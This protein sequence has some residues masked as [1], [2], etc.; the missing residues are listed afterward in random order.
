[1]TRAR[2]RETLTK[3]PTQPAVKTTKK[4]KPPLPSRLFSNPMEVINN[5]VKAACEENKD[6]AI[7]TV[8]PFVI[9]MP[10]AGQRRVSGVAGKRKLGPRSLTGT[11][12][13]GNSD[14]NKEV[15]EVED[16]PRKIQHNLASKKWRM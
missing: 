4:K 8:N 5:K 7:L 13:T 9:P 2:R 15:Q 11:V 3:P 6:P 1:M 14:L 12:T 10:V 16:R